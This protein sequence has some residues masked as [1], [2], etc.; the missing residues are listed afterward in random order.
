IPKRIAETIAIETPPK[1][2]EDT[3]IKLVFAVP[4]I[5]A[6]RKSAAERN[7]EINPVGREWEFEGA[8]VCD[9]HDPEMT[10]LKCGTDLRDISRV[11]CR[12][13]HLWAL[14]A[15]WL[16]LSRSANLSNHSASGWRECGRRVDLPESIPLISQK[17]RRCCVRFVAMEKRS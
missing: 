15:R 6:A 14:L 11:T 4:D 1:R 5:V 8:K 10:C 13:T 2:R 9:G 7:G 12:R 16:A 17:R 3:P